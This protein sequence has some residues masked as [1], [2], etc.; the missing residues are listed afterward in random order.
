VRTRAVALA[1]AALVVCATACSGSHADKAGRARAGA[2]VVLTLAAQSDLYAQGTFASAVER[3]SGGSVR[4]RIVPDRQKP[5]A[6]YERGIVRDVR[7][8]KTDLGI[9]GARVWDTIGVRSFQP[10]LAPLLVDSLSLERRALESPL[11]TRALD[12]VERAGVIGVAVL[13][14]TLRRPL[15]QTAL[16]DVCR[17]GN[18]RFVTASPEDLA[19]LRRAVSQGRVYELSWSVYRDRLSFAAEPGRE[20]VAAL[21]I[22]PLSRVG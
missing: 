17:R 11:A 14:G 19:A 12:D 3:L 10:L 20:P 21:L 2:P 5:Q 8:G 7:S 4:I 15:E 18:L 13:P 9:V 22:K 16:S 6:D 1:A